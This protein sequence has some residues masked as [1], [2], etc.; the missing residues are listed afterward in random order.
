MGRLSRKN[1][2]NRR[3][4]LSDK[5]HS[6]VDFIKD[7]T[8]AEMVLVPIVAATT[9]ALLYVFLKGD[10]VS[11]E[12]TPQEGDSITC[13]CRGEG[14]PNSSGITVEDCVDKTIKGNQE[15]VQ[16][17]K[18]RDG[19]WKAVG[20]EI[21]NGVPSRPGQLTEGLPISFPRYRTKGP[22]KCVDKDYNTRRR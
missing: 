1:S 4:T 14:L 12:Y 16:P 22:I 9:G 17:P 6:V 13:L 15:W 11:D 8:P 21:V 3:S 18:G 20:G 7:R 10:P 19:R 5:Y 2:F